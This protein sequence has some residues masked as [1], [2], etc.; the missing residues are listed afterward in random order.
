MA[1]NSGPVSNLDLFDEARQRAVPVTLYEARGVSLGWILFSVGFGGTREGYAY[2]G[3]AWSE[4]GFQVA[5]VEHVGSNLAKLKELQF[6]G[7]RQHQLAEAVS[8][9]VRD[10]EE[11]VARPLDLDF[12]RRQ[13]CPDQAWVGLGGHSFGSYTCLATLGAEAQLPGGARR[14]D[15]GWKWQGAVLMSVQPPW[16]SARGEATGLSMFSRQAF[17]QL[18]VPIMMV[19]GTRDS[20]LPTG[21]DYLERLQSFRALRGGIHHS[22]VI[23]KADHMSFAGVGIAVD[24]VITTVAALTQSF[25]LALV[26]GNEPQWPESLPLEVEFERA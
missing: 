21:V 23:G 1:A 13:L 19:T 9:R 26:Q 22:A 4:V 16:D 2:L 3:R 18:E 12:V 5:V 8:Q 25:W 11:L 10:E 15:F 20:G 14:F 6:P 24:S 17:S 7:M